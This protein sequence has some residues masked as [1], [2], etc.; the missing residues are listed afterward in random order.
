MHLGSF[1]NFVFYSISLATHAVT[2]HC[3]II[4]ALHRVLSVYLVRS[5][6]PPPPPAHTHMRT[7]THTH[8]H[9]PPDLFRIFL[10]TLVDAWGWWV[11]CLGTWYVFPF[12]EI[13]FSQLCSPWQKHWS[14]YPCLH[15][16]LKKAGKSGATSAPE[17]SDGKSMGS[18]SGRPDAP[19][20]SPLSPCSV[21]PDVFLR[22]SM[23]L[24][25]L[26]CEV[27][28]GVLF[29][30]WPWGLINVCVILITFSDILLACRI[31]IDFWIFFF[32]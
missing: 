19:F 20:S 30:R 6:W 4:D 24:N 29:T 9:T 14:L 23:S 31:T 18:A 3:L 11:L 8:A 5:S 17:S 10:A 27:R 12:A 7:L 32:F 2:P 1:L 25:L 21:I 13:Y 22:F 15:S 16:A 28:T 26:I